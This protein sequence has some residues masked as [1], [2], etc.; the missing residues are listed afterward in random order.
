MLIGAHVSTAG[1]LAKALERGGDMGCEAIQIFPQSPRM[2][3]PTAYTESDFVAY[4][5][6]QHGSPVKASL[7]H[8]IYLIN[9][10]SRETEVKRKSAA[11]LAHALRVGEGILATG[12]VLHA[13]ARKGEPHAP[14]MRRA[15][16]MIRSALDASDS[17]PLLLENTA[18]TQGPLGRD[19]DEL[20]ELIDLAG[21][22]DRLG[23][24]IDCCHLF[25]S[26]RNIVEPEGLAVERTRRVDVLE[27][28]VDVVDADGFHSNLRRSLALIPWYG[29]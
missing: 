18:G 10:A 13:G 22:D 4:R 27:H 7:I 6:A 17:C 24:C 2:W 1:G 15:A 21:A 26:G 8:A 29:G 19:L 20:A 16:T 14:S 23:I 3:R 28:Q 11:A 12:V 5:S 9:C 25:A